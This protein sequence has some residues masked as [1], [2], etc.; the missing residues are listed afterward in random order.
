MKH[1]NNS[2]SISRSK[3]TNLSIFAIVFFVFIFGCF[4]FNEDV[5]SIAEFP[6]SRQNSE[7]IPQKPSCISENFVQE[8]LNDHKPNGVQESINNDENEQNQQHANLKTDVD[9]EED[10]EQKIEMLV[11]DDDEDE[12]EIELPPEECD[13]FNGEWVFDN[14]IH[15]LYKEEQCEFLTSQVTCMRN[16][17]KDSSYQNWRWQP[18]DCSLPKFKPK[19]LLEKLRNKRLMFVGDSLNRNQWESMVCLV[20]SAVPQGLKSLYKTGSLSIFRIEVYFLD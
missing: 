2:G 14:S 18:K 4:M 9:K 19:M 5:N 17:R 12:D 20:Q 11:E 6:F 1:N 10:E 8:S 3:N 15:P 7:E 16:G 13:L